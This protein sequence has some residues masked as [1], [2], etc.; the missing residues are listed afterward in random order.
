MALTDLIGKTI[1]EVNIGLAELFEGKGNL[2]R[3]EIYQVVCT[4]NSVHYFFTYSD[5]D[6]PFNAMM[7][8]VEVR[9]IRVFKDGKHFNS[10]VITMDFVPADQYTEKVREYL[11]EHMLD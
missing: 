10:A 3:G 5:L 9:D 2:S 8:P 11:L 1:K 6:L 4:D 7:C